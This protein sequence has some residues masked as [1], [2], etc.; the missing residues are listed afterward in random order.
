[1]DKLLP[2]ASTLA[3]MLVVVASERVLAI[4]MRICG[5]AYRGKRYGR[6]GIVT[7]C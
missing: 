7:D 4:S 2:F 1:M 6:R 5:A 3:R